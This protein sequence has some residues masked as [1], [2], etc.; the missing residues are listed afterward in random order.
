MES[1]FDAAGFEVVLHVTQHA[2]HA[3]DIVRNAPL[4]QFQAVVAVGGDGT[5]FEVLQVPFLAFECNSVCMFKRKKAEDYIA[6]C[7]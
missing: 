3:T 1:I 2:G 7:T 5:A 6:R 4:E